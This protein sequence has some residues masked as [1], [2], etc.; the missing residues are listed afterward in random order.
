LQ[1]ARQLIDGIGGI[2]EWCR[3]IVDG[4]VVR[5]V[6]RLRLGYG[7]VC[8]KDARRPGDAERWFGP[9]GV[10]GVL[11]KS[12]VVEDGLWR[13]VDATIRRF[14]SELK[15]SFIAFANLVSQVDTTSHDENVH[16]LCSVR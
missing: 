15:R 1:I 5:Y 2:S 7:G 11:P 4:Y 6:E 3:D 10:G 13:K 14:V 16:S 8:G 12:R 9:Y